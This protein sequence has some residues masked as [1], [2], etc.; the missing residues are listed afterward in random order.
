MTTNMLAIFVL[1]CDTMLISIP[2]KC[3]IFQIAFDKVKSFTRFFSEHILYSGTQMYQQGVLEAVE[4]GEKTYFKE[5][6]MV[7]F[8][9]QEKA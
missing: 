1:S 5:I 6:T 2:C 3:F 7:I 9:R 8:F 4:V